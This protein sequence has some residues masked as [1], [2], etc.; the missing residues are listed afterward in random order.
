M[1]ITAKAYIEHE[2]LAL[3]PTLCDLDGVNIRVIHQ[4][5]T[6]PTSSTFPFV[7]E[8][9]DLEELEETLNRDHTVTKYERID[10]NNGTNIYQIQHTD[11]AKL[12]SPAVTQVNGFLLQSETK[13]KGWLI[14]AQLL[15]RDALN[16]V[17]EYAREND[18]N[19]RLLEL[20]EKRKGG[21][22]SS[23][24]LTEEQQKALEIAYEK[25]YFS[26]PREM[27]LED[28]ANEVG[29]S[30]TAM[31]GRLRRGMRNLLSST[32]VED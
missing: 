21:S 30:S 19:F 26:E 10:S 32:L 12:I 28:V 29:I 22:D 17:W 24:G 25:G 27:S 7:I 20:Y 6:D 14:Q 1:S 11:T 18:I 16:S 2:D 15:S 3:V 23:F 8:Y 4:A 13:D 9:D 31:S 5:T